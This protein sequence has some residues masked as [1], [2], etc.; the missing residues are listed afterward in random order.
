MSAAVHGGTAKLLPDVDRPRAWLLTLDG[1]PQSYVD[2]ENPRHLE[3]EYA[4]RVG[5][6]LDT[7]APPGSPLAVL[8]CGAGALTLPRYVAA[9]RAGSRQHVVDTDEPLLAFVGA[10][11]P[12]P[13]GSGIAVETADARAALREQRAGSLDAVISDVYG[14]TR[15]PAHL[16]TLS[17]LRA[18]QR[19]LGERGRFVANIADSAPFRFLASQLATLAAVFTHTCL[20]AEAGVLRGRRF[21]NTVLVGSNE[22]LPLAELARCCAA[23]PFPARVVEGAELERIAAGARAVQ[24]G[25]EAPS[26]E[27]PEGA[28]SVGGGTGTSEEAGGSG[29]LAT[30]EDPGEHPAEASSGEPGERRVR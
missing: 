18:A 14:G 21:G 29:R 19:A 25:E 24:D 3:F 2:L 16:T 23:D 15:V 20:I 1:A 10:H 28:F 30:A 27:P 6:V 17:Y 9:T 26:P 13:D 22:P 7:A 4:R 8:H 11:L 5:H 12:L